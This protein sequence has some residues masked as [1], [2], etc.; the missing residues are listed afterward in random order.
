[1][2]GGTG[3]ANTQWNYESRSQT[4]N[5]LGIPIWKYQQLNFDVRS[6]VAGS[7]V[8]DPSK[9]TGAT[10]RWTGCLEE[11]ATT[12]GTMSF[13]TSTLPPDLDPDLV[14]NSNIDTQW[15]PM[16]PELFYARNNYSS[17][18]TATSTGDSSSSPN[19]GTPYYYQLGYVS[20]GKPVSRLAV[21]TRT[22]VSSYVN[23]SDFRPIGGTYHDTGMIWGTRLLS[24]T[25]LFAADTASWPARQAP[26]R[27]IVFLTDGDMA[28]STSIYGMYGNE[29]Y[30]R[31]VS[32]G[33]F[34]NL[35]AYHNARF[36]AECAAAKARNIQIWT[37]TI[38]SS[39]TTQMQSCATTTN[40]ALATTTG[41]GLS[42]AFATIAKQVAM[43]RVSQ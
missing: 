30:D 1:M 19:I 2:V 34:T 4:G 33:D 32:G 13:N 16:W 31:R 14:P 8:T 26:N 35:K 9:T 24:P 21:M 42:T 29:Y 41:A 7:T 15:K 28:P 37:V 11:R 23:A 36:L 5:L 39:A 6:F 12:A 25:G 38:D 17:T 22:Q 43:L 20:C 3:S 27:V 40:Q 10:N 18:A